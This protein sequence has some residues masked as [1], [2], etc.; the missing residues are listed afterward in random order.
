M[1]ERAQQMGLSNLE[2]TGRWIPKDELASYLGRAGVCLGVF[3]QREKT[4]RVIP[5]KIFDYLAMA[6]PLI[7]A[8]TPA[9]RELLTHGENAYLCP[10]GNPQALATQILQLKNNPDLRQKIAVN[11]YQTY[12]R[13]CAS[14]RV[15]KELIQAFS[16]LIQSRAA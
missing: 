6:K 9:I 2:F 14:D 10:I 8:D 5:C 1:K 12:S 4:Q 15:G 13:F 11:G 7:T 3:G 16:T